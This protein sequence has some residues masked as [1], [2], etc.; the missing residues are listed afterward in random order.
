MVV[1]GG[2]DV[3]G[4]CEVVING[5]YVTMAKSDGCAVSLV[6]VAGSGGGCW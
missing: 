4:G 5:G 1:V 6:V 3:N 2:V